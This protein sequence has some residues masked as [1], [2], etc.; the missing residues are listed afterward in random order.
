MNRLEMRILL[1]KIRNQREDE[2]RKK[3][4]EKQK[5]IE[6]YSEFWMKTD[7]RNREFEIGSTVYK[8]RFRKDKSKRGRIAIEMKKAKNA[9]SDLRKRMGFF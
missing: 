6:E 4:E 3:R 5:K 1:N 9:V 8:P 7:K 2:E